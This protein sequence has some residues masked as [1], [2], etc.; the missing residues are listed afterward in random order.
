MRRRTYSNMALPP[1]ATIIAT[2]YYNGSYQTWTVP[3]TGWYKIE[4]WGAQGCFAGSYGGYTCGYIR[5]TAGV[6]LYIYCGNGKNNVYAATFNGGGA[7]FYISSNSNSFGAGGGAT[8]VRLVSG[9]W[10]DLASLKSRIMVAGAG[11]GNFSF[12]SVKKNGGGGLIGYNGGYIGVSA[13][14]EY[15]QG[16]TQLAGGAG[17]TVT[18][19]G[20]WSN[21]DA[22]G[23]GYGGDAHSDGVTEGGTGGGSGY[24]GGGGGGTRSNSIT[25][26]AGGSSFIS[27]HDGCDAI[28]SSGA[29]TGQSIHYSG[30]KFINTLM[31]D[32]QG[33]QWTTAKGS[34]M[35]MP[36][37]TG[38]NYSSGYGHQ[39]YGYCRISKM[40]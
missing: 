31:I 40:S 14:L 38:G 24:Y 8:D 22:G 21:G 5:L 25:A 11:G 30:H 32:G 3:T 17:A 23:L 19:V 10:N 12:S 37:P 39:N 36:N 29:H 16:G 27:G 35:L 1:N 33:Y 13:D 20:N 15:A 18:Q 28:D 6:Q 2:L 34:K 4:C 26:G 9:A 7:G